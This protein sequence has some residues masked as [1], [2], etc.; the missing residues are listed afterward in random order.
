[1]SMKK[2]LAIAAATMGL[3][4]VLAA[5]VPAQAA[6]TQST[7]EERGTRTDTSGAQVAWESGGYGTMRSGR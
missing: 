3:A 5:A 6:R 2:R 4:M 7:D 1:M